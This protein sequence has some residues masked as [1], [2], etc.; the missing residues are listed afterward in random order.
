MYEHR[1]GLIK[2]GAKR[3]GLS[4]IKAIVGDA[5]VKKTDLGNF[6]V[7]LCDVPCSGLGVIRRK[8]EIKYKEIDADEYK[9]LLE[10]QQK[11]LE[12]ADF[13]LKPGGTLVYSTCTLKKDENEAQI[14]DFLDKHGNYDV[15]YNVNFMPHIDGSDGF[16]TAI[17]YKKR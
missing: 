6:D 14:T 13:Y 3:L 5:T 15:K 2:E 12:N 17:L 16:F 11:I 8:P 7:V 10:T 1:V 4:N 9:I